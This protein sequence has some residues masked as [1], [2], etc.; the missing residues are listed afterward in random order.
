MYHIHFGTSGWRDIIADGF[1]MEGVTAVT[2]A[3]ASQLKARGMA[4]KGVLVGHDSRFLSENFS[5]RAAEILSREGIPVYLVED[6]APTPVLAAAILDLS[7][8]GGINFTASH[9]PAQYQGMKWS[10]EHG[11]PATKDEVAPIE[12]EANRLLAG[13]EKTAPAGT[14][15][16]IRT[17]NPKP[18]YMKR[19]AKMIPMKVLQAKRLSVVADPLFGAG[20]GYLD[21]ALE[22]AGCRVSLLHDWRDALF[23]G[24]S[25]EPNDENLR[26][27]AQVMKKKKAVLALGTDGDA[28]RFGVVDRDGT[29]LTPNQVLALTVYLLV[30][31]RGWKGRVV[32]SVV[33]SHLVD[34]VANQYGLPV[35]VTPV[36]FKYI[37]ESMVRGGFLVGGEE[38]GG[39]T[40]AGHV[41]EKDGVL[42]CLLMAELVAREK[43]SLGAIL[44][45]ITDKTGNILTDRI[46]MHL[47]STGLGAAIKRRLDQ[48]QPAKLA[49]RRVT[50]V[51]RT[52]GYKYILDNGDWLAI[53]LSGTEPVARLYL[54]ARSAAGLKRL[55]SEG[56]T[57]LAEG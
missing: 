42:A 19:L 26:E 20:R 2:R 15:A 40:I 30:K 57:L 46:N 24:K 25:P 51:D 10:N 32:R 14:P 16:T 44:K 33:T 5:A 35:E 41:P 56:K 6:P 18:A 27:A 23:G 17:Y 37:G 53:R 52:D 1:T 29:Y 36:G 38:S 12:K 28:D 3:I 11:G 4:G 31:H 43:K 48:H 54:E 45:S 50:Q 8:A 47:D 39:R 55:A 49:G 7:L 21:Q 13:G 34:A 9:N 22:A